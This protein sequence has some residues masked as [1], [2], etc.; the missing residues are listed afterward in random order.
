[1]F[2][3]HSDYAYPLSCA[4][5]KPVTFLQTNSGSPPAHVRWASGHTYWVNWE[6]LQLPLQSGAIAAAGSVAGLRAAEAAEAAAPAAGAAAAEAVSFDDVFGAS[7]E[8]LFMVPQPS[9]PSAK[10]VA[11]RRRA[12]VSRCVALLAVYPCAECREP[13][14]GGR[15]ECAADADVYPGAMFC[16]PCRFQKQADANKCRLHGYKYAV[17]KCDSCC[18]VATFDCRSN[19]YCDR[20]HRIPSQ[21]KKFPC[22]GDCTTGEGCPL[23]MPHPPN[24]AGAHGEV[25]NGFVIACIQCFGGSSDDGGG[26]AGGGGAAAQPRSLDAMA[27]FKGAVSDSW[28][29]RF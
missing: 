6:D 16:P 7:L 17:Y 24:K 27:N 25:D 22:P 20:C 9:P 13:F 18:A 26:A 2:V 5:L 10:E 1:L 12:A 8:H 29:S 28:A 19:H 23:G 14:S 3:R 15:V 11:A 21:H 4:N